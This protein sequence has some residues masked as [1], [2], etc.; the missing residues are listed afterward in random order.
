MNPLESLLIIYKDKQK[1]L[2]HYLPKE[3]TDQLHNTI[4]F[5]KNDTLLYL[6]DTIFCILKSTGKITEKG[7]IIRIEQNKITLKKASNNITINENEYFIFIKQK[8]KKN[9][10]NRDFFKELLEQLN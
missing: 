2:D 3:T 10:D 5:D 9:N 8:K 6:N 4:Y 7:K 1:V